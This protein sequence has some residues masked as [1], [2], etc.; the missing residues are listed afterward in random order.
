M[1]SHCP[2]PRILSPESVFPALTQFLPFDHHTLPV[3][4]VCKPESPLDVILLSPNLRTEE[5]L[6][7]SLLFSVFCSATNLSVCPQRFLSLSLVVS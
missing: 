6:F 2:L 1:E 3:H 4:W 5:A 7:L